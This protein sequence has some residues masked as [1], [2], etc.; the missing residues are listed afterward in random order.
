MFKSSIQ[1]VFRKK[2]RTVCEFEFD[3]RFIRSKGSTKNTVGKEKKMELKVR[4][5]CDRKERGKADPDIGELGNTKC[6]KV[7]AFLSL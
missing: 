1:L 6:R 2:K 5:A 3:W 7:N 4:E